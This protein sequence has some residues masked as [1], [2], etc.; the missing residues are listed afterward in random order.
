MKTDGTKKSF[1]VTVSVV[2][3]PGAGVPP[4]PVLDL[5]GVERR[6]YL[7]VLSGGGRVGKWWRIRLSY[8]GGTPP[9]CGQTPVRTWASGGS[10]VANGT[11]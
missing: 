2:A 10:L 7:P 5:M 4:G 1:C 8:P 6:G 11:E 3:C 9:P